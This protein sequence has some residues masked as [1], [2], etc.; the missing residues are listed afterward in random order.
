MPAPSIPLLA[1][2]MG[3]AAGTGPEIITK[4]LADPALAAVARPLVVGDAATMER[5]V[6]FTRAPVTIRAIQS[7]AAAKFVPGTIDVLDLANIDA[8]RLQL[9]Q[10]DAMAGQA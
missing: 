6:G 3:D 1:I 10:V 4:A 7:V 5:A 2:T 8:A 9:G